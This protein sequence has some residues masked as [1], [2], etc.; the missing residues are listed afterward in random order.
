MLGL[1]GGDS[2]SSHV[3]KVYRGDIP[4]SVASEWMTEDKEL[5]ALVLKAFR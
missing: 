1:S 4:W 5:L 3:Y 2:S